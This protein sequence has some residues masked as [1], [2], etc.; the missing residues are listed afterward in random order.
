MRTFGRA[1][2]EAATAR[3]HVIHLRDSLTPTT[4]MSGMGGK[5]TLASA[6]VVLH[7]PEDNDMTNN[8]SSDR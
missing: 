5:R 1:A 7:F 3:R 6:I 4:L 8:G 2:R